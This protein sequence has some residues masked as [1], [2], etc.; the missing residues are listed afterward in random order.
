MKF[1]FIALL[2]AV[3]Q[4]IKV[5]SVNTEPSTLI[6]KDEL[7]QEDA[8]EDVDVQ[9]NDDEDAQEWSNNGILPRVADEGRTGYCLGMVWYGANHRMNGK[10]MWGSFD[11]NNRVFGDPIRGVKKSCHCNG[12]L[13]V[14]N[15]GRKGYCISGRVS[16]GARGRYVTKRFRYTRWFRCNNRVFGDSYPGVKKQCYCHK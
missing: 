1:V 15:E 2:A 7:V 13:K 16:Y 6:Q 5:E 8:Y 10:R 12:A 3:A 4:S 9:E 11:C 14:A